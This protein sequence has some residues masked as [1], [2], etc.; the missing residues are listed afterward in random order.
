M[1]VAIVLNEAFNLPA[2]ASHI[3]PAN[4]RTYELLLLIWSSQ[5]RIVLS[6]INGQSKFGSNLGYRIKKLFADRHESGISISE[7]VPEFVR[8]SVLFDNM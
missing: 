2:F 8:V 3:P 5:I 4:H 1:H 7:R 6:P